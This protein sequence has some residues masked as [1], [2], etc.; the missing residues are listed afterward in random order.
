MWCE[1]RAGL[2]G[3]QRLLMVSETVLSE[4]EVD[5]SATVTR[6]RL[7]ESLEQQVSIFPQ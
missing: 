7:S 1:V 4:A 5:G 3:A 6:H 2:S